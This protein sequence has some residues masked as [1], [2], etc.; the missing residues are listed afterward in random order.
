M[1]VMDLQRL[2]P[3]ELRHDRLRGTLL[4]QFIEAA[5]VTGVD[6]HTKPVMERIN[7]LLKQFTW[8]HVIDDP[9]LA[10][11]Q[12]GQQ[13]V[14]REV[15]EIL[16][17]RVHEI[18]RTGMDAKPK[19]NELRRLPHDLRRAI[20]I[21]QQQQELGSSTY[22]HAQVLDRGLID[23]M[24]GLSD[25]GAYELHARLKGREAFGHL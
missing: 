15:F 9:T 11:I 24:A 6:L 8:Y 2:V 17:P 1:L 14:L 12:A 25:K 20:V 13:R 4:G 3:Q 10:N 7:A 5:S 23:F 22:K 19:Q 21:G 18:Y 16:R